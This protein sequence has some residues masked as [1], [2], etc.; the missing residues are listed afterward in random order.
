MKPVYV[1]CSGWNYRDWR[2]RLYPP[3]TPERRWLETYAGR[4]DTVEVNATF[5]RLATRKPSSTG[6]NRP[7]KGSSS[8]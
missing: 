1:G 8:Q 6:S 5:Y 3:G 7:P 4:F 2:S